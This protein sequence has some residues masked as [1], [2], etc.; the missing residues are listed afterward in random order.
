MSLRRRFG[1][2]ELLISFFW[3]FFLFCFWNGKYN[4]IPTVPSSLQPVIADMFFS[5]KPSLG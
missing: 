1:Y 2:V 5:S 4:L 3:F